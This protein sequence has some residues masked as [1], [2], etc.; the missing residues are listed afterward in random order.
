MKKW[1]NPELMILGVEN[2]KDDWVEYG[3]KCPYPGCGGNPVSG[4]GHGHGYEKCLELGCHGP[5]ED[6]PTPNPS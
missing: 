2:T 5:I 4:S 1:E 3:E 6:L